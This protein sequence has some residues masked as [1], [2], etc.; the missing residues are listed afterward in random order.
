[1]HMDYSHSPADLCNNYV[2]YETSILIQTCL[3]K[4]S[5]QISRSMGLTAIFKVTTENLLSHVLVTAPSNA[6][7]YV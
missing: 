7:I 2:F 3:D 6:V 1:M 5:S 4:R